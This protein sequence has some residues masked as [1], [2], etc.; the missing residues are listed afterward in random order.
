MCKRLTVFAVFGEVGGGEE[1]YKLFDFKL[2]YG[3]FGLNSSGLQTVGRRVSDAV[4]RSR[5]RDRFDRD[6]II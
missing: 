3:L 6:N 4:R 5:A 1:T 2:A